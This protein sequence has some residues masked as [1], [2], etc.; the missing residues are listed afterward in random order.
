MRLAPCDASGP[1]PRSHV[2][3]ARARGRHFV[4]RQFL[5]KLAMGADSGSPRP[6]LC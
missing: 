6:R 5:V 4:F 1:G 3:D 2:D